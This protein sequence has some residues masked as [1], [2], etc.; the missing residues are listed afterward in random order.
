VAPVAAVRAAARALRRLSLLPVDE[1]GTAVA[2]TLV[3]DVT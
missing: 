3:P 2:D 1:V